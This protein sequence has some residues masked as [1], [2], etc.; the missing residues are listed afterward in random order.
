YNRGVEKRL[1]FQTTSNYLRFMIN[2]YEFNDTAP[3]RNLGYHAARVPIE[4][5]L[6]YPR[7]RQLVHILAY[8]L[9]PNHFHL[10]VQSRDDDGI[11]EFMRKL[12]TGYTNY[13]NIKYDRVGPLFQGKFKSILLEQDAHLT[14]LPH[15]IHL[16]PLDLS[17]PKWRE[18][19]IQ[20]V[21]KALNFLR[22]Y[23][24]S[25]FP[26]YTGKKNFPS[27]IDR[28]FLAEYIGTPKAFLAG[29]KEWIHDT[30]FDL[31]QKITME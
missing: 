20:D 16:N 11:T 7:K 17:M 27:V 12:G 29:T 3:A 6:Q 2:L 8:C 1:I 26:D 5:R 18:H 4:V 25:S 31:V 9:M 22:A 14:H 21:Q 19:R 23:R 10:M 13:F 15:Y 24:W 28:K 30:Q